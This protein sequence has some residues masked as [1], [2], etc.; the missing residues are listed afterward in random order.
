MADSSVALCLQARTEDV[1]D[2][3]A[4]E[5]TEDSMGMTWQQQEAVRVR[6]QDADI[7]ARM[8]AFNSV[9]YRMPLPHLS[10]YRAS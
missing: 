5:G 8:R 4:E 1:A 2:I 10:R 9:P 7:A 3:Y 6:Q